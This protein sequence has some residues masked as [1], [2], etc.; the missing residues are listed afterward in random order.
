MEDKIT[1]VEVDMD[2]S[3]LNRIVEQWATET[4]FVLNQKNEKRILYSKNIRL[5]TAW[6]S[7]EGEG[8]NAKIIAWIAPKGLKPDV[9][10][11]AWSG[12]KMAVSNGPIFGPAAIYRKQ[13]NKLMETLKIKSANIVTNNNQ[14]KIE[15]RTFVNILVAI[16]A[17]EF[18][19]GALSVISAVTFTT[20]YPELG[21]IS[22]QNGIFNMVLGILTLIS[23]QML[24]NGK[25][26]ALWLYG[27]TILLNITYEIAMGHKF[28]YLSIFFSAL[29][30]WQLA[31]S[32]KEWGLA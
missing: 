25:E 12:W 3:E 28:P 1:V 15:K 22:L 10:G 6:L 11:N 23:S 31:T 5:N 29:I 32:K 2:A 21:N 17:I 7:I 14:P 8:E 26:L 27:S 30:I 20:S 13:F 16:G 9:K 24:K 19:S 4:K 18:L